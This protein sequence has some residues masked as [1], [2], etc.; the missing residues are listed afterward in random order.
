MFNGLENLMMR[1]KSITVR[2]AYKRYS[3]INSL[4][5]LNMSVPIGTMYVLIVTI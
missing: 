4:Q 3:N 5:G 2:D 1:E